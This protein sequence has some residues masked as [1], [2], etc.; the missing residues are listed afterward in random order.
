MFAM[1]S[2]IQVSGCQ[3]TEMVKNQDYGKDVAVLI[4]THHQATHRWHT[5]FSVLNTHSKKWTR[6]SEDLAWRL[7]HITWQAGRAV[8]L[9]RNPYEALISF[10]NHDRSDTYDSAQD[11]GIHNL[12]D[13]LMSKLF[14]D[15]VK[16][17]IGLWEEI[18]VDFLSYGTHIMAVHYEL[19][20]LDPMKG[21]KQIHQFLGV[22][23][24]PE[25]MQCIEERPST[26]YK[27]KHQSYT[28]PYDKDLTA[29]VEASITKVQKLLLK[30]NL[31]PLPLPLYKLRTTASQ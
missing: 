20:K 19:F 30:R 9:I 31:E 28:N 29:L 15:F 18:Y 16:V 11:T 8:V 25:R 23:I 27:R 17:E 6:W 24:N 26:K 3:N 10:W 1:S 13:T 22:P 5:N 2:G 4:K 12:G 14:R 7:R 21:L